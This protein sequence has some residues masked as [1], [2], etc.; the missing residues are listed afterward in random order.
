[1]SYETSEQLTARSAF[2][3]PIMRKLQIV[4]TA[5][6]IPVLLVNV[7]C[8]AATGLVNLASSFHDCAVPY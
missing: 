1:M 2:V 4:G 3:G 5:P 8:Q 7:L 6:E